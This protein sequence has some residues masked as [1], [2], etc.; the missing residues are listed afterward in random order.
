MTVSWQ[1][2]FVS[3]AITYKSI[4]G[5]NLCQLFCI[6][7]C[8]CTR[9]EALLVFL[10]GTIGFYN[11]YHHQCLYWQKKT[12]RKWENI[13]SEMQESSNWHQLTF[14][15]HKKIYVKMAILLVKKIRICRSVS[16]VKLDNC[17]LNLFC[18]VVLEN[19][20]SRGQKCP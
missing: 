19:Q 14:E 20:V 12:T 11:L 5:S 6:I 10:C 15:M 7:L 13:A 3:F 1:N 18:T 4:V 2:N 16:E 9:I 17:P 8:V